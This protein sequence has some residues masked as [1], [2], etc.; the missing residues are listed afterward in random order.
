[1]SGRCKWPLHHRDTFAPMSRVMA[2]AIASIASIIVAALV[3]PWYVASIGGGF[4]IDHITFDLREARACS[5][6]GP[7]GV[8]PMS[9]VKGG[10]Y[11][12]LAQ[13]AF[14]GS[15]LFAAILA[16]QAGTKL[17]SGFSNET[18]SRAAHAVSTLVVLASVGAGYLFGPDLGSA[19][20]MGLSIEVER[21][22]GPLMMLLGLML[23]NVALYYARDATADDEPVYIPVEVPPSVV[24]RNKT[25]ATVDRVK[26][27]TTPPTTRPARSPTTPPQRTTSSP[28]TPP[29]AALKGKVQFAVLTA[30]VTVAGVDA[31]REDG[32]TILV[33]WRDVVGLVVRRLPSELEGHVFVDI[34]STAGMTLRVLPWTKLTGEAFE[35]D[36]EARARVF[37]ERVRPRCPDAKLDRATLNFLEGNKAAQLPNLDVLAKHDQALA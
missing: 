10:M 4:E 26:P 32:E 6:A 24:A 19:T 33:L 29:P 16:Y 14:W 30:E 25:P 5:S 15:L 7:C 11:T 8:V 27:P 35:G 2:F 34:V 37:V 17:L 31:R 22:W 13:I 18:V 1:M 21:G 36:G 12:P 20:L 9:M 23:G 28:T 3:L